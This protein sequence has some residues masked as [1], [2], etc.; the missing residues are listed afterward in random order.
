MA[1]MAVDEQTTAHGGIQ[2]MT[3]SEFEPGAETASTH[4]NNQSIQ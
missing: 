1:L 4:R 3:L 2:G